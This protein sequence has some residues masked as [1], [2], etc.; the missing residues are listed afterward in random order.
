[1]TLTVGDSVVSAAP[2]VRNLGVMMDRHL[3]MDNQVNTISKACYYQLRNIG[4]I[5]QHIRDGA[6]KTLMQALV[7]SRLSYANALLYDV[8]Q[9]MFA[10]LQRVQNTAA[11]LVTRTR[12][13][14]ST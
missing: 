14:E 1:M 2:C 10:Q 3:T 4:H 11:L 6:C 7:M 9:P 5:R 13:N 8:P 12:K